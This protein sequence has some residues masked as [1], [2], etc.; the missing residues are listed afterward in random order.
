MAVT[1]TM[2]GTGYVGLVTGACFAEL[3][4]DVICVDKDEAKIALL[5]KG[6]MPIYEDG[7]EVLVARN[8]AAGRL[9]FSTDLSAS[10]K[11]REAV[12]I[13]V[14][15]PSEGD[16]G[17]ADL[18]YVF[19]AVRE[20]AAALDGFTV[21]VTKSTVPVGTNRQVAS[22]AASLLAPGA[23]VA[24]ASNPEFMREGVAIGDFLK[25]DRIVIGAED[26]YAID[27]MSRIYA[28]LHQG[29]IPCVM[30]GIETAE[31]I[32]Y[33]ANTFLAV[34]VSFINEIADLC[35]AVGADV[36]SV[37]EGIGLDARIGAAFLKPGPGWGGSCF[38][39]DT[40]ALHATAQDA[41]VPVRIVEAAM[42]ANNS[43][44]KAMA[45][46]ITR[47]CGGDVMDKRIAL[48]GLT[49]KGQTDDMRDSPSL[50]IVPL[51]AAKGAR[52]HAFDPAHPRDA[53]SRLP[54]IIL[55]KTPIESVRGA[56]AL[57]ILTDWSEFRGYD[58]S[59]LAGL[60]KDPVLIDLRNLYTREA[61]LAAGFRAYHRVGA[62]TGRHDPA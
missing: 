39:K 57:V 51:L 44:K 42:E 15:T 45:R 21:I 53:I 17:R 30:T 29:I 25:P 20:I 38:P 1:I 13:A 3:G 8:V 58:L 2:V 33:A 41:G 26:P 31:M 48:F 40:R 35:E 62:P 27:V 22:I 43:R 59:E 47:L 9:R 37:A 4:H 46:R 60:M 7:L 54:E 5:R 61:V 49:F 34:K 14:G 16:T 10:V 19:T 23:A 11:G 28:P 18:Q 52:I 32:K 12:F 36:E 6:T 50:D 55:E 24:V 56:E